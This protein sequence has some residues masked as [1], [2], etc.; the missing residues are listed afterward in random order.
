VNPVAPPNSW[1]FIFPGGF[2]KIFAEI[3][4][5]SGFGK[6]EPLMFDLQG[7]WSRRIDREHRLVYKVEGDKVIV[8]AC[9]YH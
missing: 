9:R 5:G 6:P 2:M 8:V 4:P 3:S 7:C 1:I